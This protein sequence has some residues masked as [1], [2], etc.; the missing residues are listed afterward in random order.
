MVLL[1]L[2]LKSTLP[3]SNDILSEHWIGTLILS[4]MESTR[5][6]T[7]T[8]RCDILEMLLAQCTLVKSVAVHSD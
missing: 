5:K 7:T 4:S 6:W 2:R 8:R 1:K 3:T